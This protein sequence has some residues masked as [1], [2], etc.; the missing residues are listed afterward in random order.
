MKKILLSSFVAL[1]IGAVSFAQVPEM[2][3]R[4]LVIK[5]TET[6]CGPCGGWGWDLA[7]Q[8]IGDLGD[9]GYYIGAMGSSSPSSMNAN[10]YSAFQYN[11][12]ISGYPTF[13]V[14]DADGGYYLS[15]ISPIYNSFYS[16]TP[17]ASPAG[18]F[19]IDGSTLT[20][21]AKTKFW[22]N[23]DGEYYIS[24]LLVEDKVLASQNGRSGT[25]EHHHILRGS[26]NSDLS[27][28]GQLLHNG[29]ITN[30]T[31]YDKVFTYTIPDGFVKENL[32]VLLVVYKKEAGKYKFVNTMMAKKATTS[33][34]KI[35]QNIANV[36]LYPN[37]VIAEDVKVDISLVQSSNLSINVV[38]INGRIVYTVPSQNYVAGNNTIVIPSSQ[39]S[40]G[41]FFVNIAG[42]NI[43]HNT[44][45]I[46]R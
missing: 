31:E 9:K 40:K 34:D 10:C 28:W 4:S 17:D 35:N 25:V 46:V 3:S 38:D 6:W 39:F 43:K 22:A 23:V 5:F 29:S 24:A 1:G 13:I 14:N 26:L 32:E 42:E 44:S 8:I 2:K 12:P 37:P 15:T 18:K 20:V 33:N 36:N 16:T 11:Y 30:G 41:M 7:E 27:P 19:T 45:F 21:A